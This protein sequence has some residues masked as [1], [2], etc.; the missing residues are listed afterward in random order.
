MYPLSST[1]ADDHSLVC[2]DPVLFPP[3]KTQ[4]SLSHRPPFESPAKA[5]ARLKAKVLREQ[6]CKETESKVGSRDRETQD[7]GLL[8]PRKRQH[9]WTIAELKENQGVSFYPYEA[10]TLT[11]SPTKSP[12]KAFSLP[13]SNF[14]SKDLPLSSPGKDMGRVFKT[15]NRLSPRKEILGASPMKARPLAS[16]MEQQRPALEEDVFRASCSGTPVKVQPPS[17]KSFGRHAGGLSGDVDIMENGH[18]QTTCWSSSEPF[19]L[20]KLP[21]VGSPAKMFA[22]MKARQRQKEQMGTCIVSSSTQEPR[23]GGNGVLRCRS[24]STP[25]P[26]E[27]DED[28]SVDAASSIA[29][30]AFTAPSSVGVVDSQ[31]ES[32]IDEGPL[33]P[34]PALVDDPLLHASPR[35]SIPKKCQA[36]F[37]SKNIAEAAGRRHW[38]DSDL[39]GIHLKEWLLSFNGRGLFVDG[40]RR[41]NSMQWHSN[42][43]TERVSS[44]VVKTVSG[45]TYVLVGK[46]AL[47]RTTTLPRWLQKKFMFGFPLKWKMYFD[48]FLSESQHLGSDNTR[49]QTKTQRSISLSAT[50]KSARPQ[51][52]RTPRSVPVCPPSTHNLTG[53][54]KVS[55]SGRVIK[56]PL[57]YWKGGR[58]ILDANMNVTVLQGY[59]TSICEPSVNTTVAKEKKAK[60]PA[61]VFLPS[62]DDSSDQEDLVLVRKVKMAHRPQ[63]SRSNPE[64][65]P[66]H[67]NTSQGCNLQPRVFSLP[68]Q[69]AEAVIHPDHASQPLAPPQRRSQ[70]NA[71]RQSSEEDSRPSGATRKPQSVRTEPPNVTHSKRTNQ[72]KKK[73][74][75]D[76]GQ[77]EQRDVEREAGRRAHS[78]STAD[79]LRRSRRG[80]DLREVSSE[81]D[82]NFTSTKLRSR[83]KYSRV[84]NSDSETQCS[85]V[86][87]SNHSFKFSEDED[88]SLRSKRGNSQK[89]KAVA[90]NKTAPRSQ[91]LLKPEPEP[92]A[93]AEQRDVGRRAH[94]QSAPDAVRTRRRGRDLEV[95]TESDSN[96]TST[97][98]RNRVL[99]SDSETQCSQVSLS[100]HSFKF[101]ED[102]DMS[103]RSK[104]GNSQKPKAV[105]KNKTKAKTKSPPEKLQVDK[106]ST[107]VKKSRAGASANP[108]EEEEDDDRWTEAELRR[109]HE[110]VTSFPKHMG[111]FWLNVAMAVRTRSAEECQERYTAQKSCPASSVKPRKKEGAAAKKDPVEPQITAKVGTLKRKQQIRNFL[112]HMPKDDHDDIFT[113]SPMQSKRVKLPTASPSWGDSVFMSSGQDPQTPCSA[114]FPTVKTPQ[115]LHITPGMM[116]SVNKNDDKYIYQLQKRMK[117]SQAQVYKY[118]RTSKKFTPTPPLKRAVK[119][120]DIPEENDSFVIREMFP[121]ESRVSDEGEE[122]DYYFDDD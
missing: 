116:G 64:K 89:P 97:K 5:F 80:H 110:T 38:Q 33:A 55:R 4:N 62:P 83:K 40:L 43:I 75:S 104:R 24:T 94:S 112:E 95:S 21:F 77:A 54:A 11:L 69:R 12:P 96:F 78:Q 42:V 59:E 34:C 122:E 17:L 13:F 87:L 76:C 84:L 45:N 9:P 39:E 52:A 22:S 90:K 91:A 70:R 36:M 115:C 15:V 81:S 58:I 63:R 71:G 67:T 18:P 14:S 113:S 117:T 20:D 88:M 121:D 51:K 73:E 35:I 108:Q 93:Q 74:K 98:L 30:T 53:G 109:L 48:Q 82:C 114:S 25:I 6:M 49:G 111:S 61:K 1:M 37:L 72:K 57:E 31:Y 99:I 47:D 56:P 102:E 92:Q 44:N 16:S 68:P 100:N 107:R 86:S 103:L 2:G 65:E 7:G 41:D 119:R 28:T 50:P 79:A 23:R 27:T 118:V 29:G 66:S 101:S 19:A 10:E 105:T 106:Q 60:K 85:Q 46:M 26:Q 3:L 120:C 8:S 32:D